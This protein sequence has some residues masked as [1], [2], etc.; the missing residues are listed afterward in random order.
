MYEYDSE[1]TDEESEETRSG[2]KL[3]PTEN[4]QY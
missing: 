1:G 3:F 4:L 2:R